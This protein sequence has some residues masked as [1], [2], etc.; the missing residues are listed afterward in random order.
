MSDFTPTWEH[1]L[2]LRERDFD[3]LGHLTAAAYLEVLEEARTVWL[4]STVVDGPPMY[5]VAEQNIRYRREIRQGD[6]PLRILIAPSLD[7]PQRYTV[8]ETIVSSAGNV[9]A[10]SRAVLVAWDP[11]HRRP[12]DLN[13]LELALVAPPL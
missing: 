1:T 4:R 12:R 2:V 11:V 7:S 5:V 9:H 13:E 6:S 10:V 8:N 3:G